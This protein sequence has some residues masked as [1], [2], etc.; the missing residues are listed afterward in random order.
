MYTVHELCHTCTDAFDI[1]YFKEKVFPLEAWH[2]HSYWCSIVMD[3]IVYM[4]TYGLKMINECVIVRK[5]RMVLCGLMHASCV[6]GHTLTHN[7]LRKW[8]HN[9]WWWWFVVAIIL[10]AIVLQ[11]VKRNLI[12][13][14]WNMEENSSHTPRERAR[15]WDNMTELQYMLA[16]YVYLSVMNAYMIYLLLLM[17]PIYWILLCPAILFL[18]YF[19]HLLT[20]SLT[21]TPLNISY[22]VFCPESHRPHFIL[23]TVCVCWLCMCVHYCQWL[24]VCCDDHLYCPCIEP[25]NGKEF[26]I[27]QI[28]PHHVQVTHVVCVRIH[29]C[30]VQPEFGTAQHTKLFLMND[31]MAD[32]GWV[33]FSLLWLWLLLVSVTHDWIFIR[34]YQTLGH[35]PYGIVL[36]L[37]FFDFVYLKF[38]IFIFIHGHI[39]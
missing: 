10:R 19:S 8:H 30:R 37:L 20:H 36:L 22:L 6:C 4:V 28:N 32:C 7:I 17:I 38:Y 16:C 3:D 21:L 35:F 5:I 24:L 13:Q 31:S 26:S 18:L 23:N 34:G 33:Y 2:S 29:F 27:I 39:I 25:T 9:G 15:D 11:R 14:Y 1:F 12:K